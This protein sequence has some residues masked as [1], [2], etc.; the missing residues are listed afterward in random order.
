MVLFFFSHRRLEIKI[1]LHSHMTSPLW[2]TALD[3]WVSCGLCSISNVEVVNISPS[4]SPLL[5]FLD[6]RRESMVDSHL[7]NPSSVTLHTLPL[8][9]VKMQFVTLFFWS[10]DKR[11]VVGSRMEGGKG[12]I[13]TQKLLNRTKWKAVPNLKSELTSVTLV[14]SKTCFSSK[15]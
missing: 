12:W 3:I 4:S 1:W 13:R 11:I 7:G 9:F 8:P 10:K 14:C 5:F 6:K 15:T 2:S